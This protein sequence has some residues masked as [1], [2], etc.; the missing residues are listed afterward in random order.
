LTTVSPAPGLLARLLQ[1]YVP[2]VA[3]LSVSAF[4]GV[5]AAPVFDAVSYYLYSFAKDSPLYDGDVF[6]YLTGLAISIMT[7]LLAGIPAALYERVR[8]LPQSTAMSMAIWLLAAILLSV[9]TLLRL[10][11][12]D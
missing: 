11:G 2:L 9:P 12:E 7:F 3:I 10:F 4:N 1:R 8:G 6:Y 5:D